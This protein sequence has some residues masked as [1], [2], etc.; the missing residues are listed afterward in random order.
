MLQN[1]NDMQIISNMPIAKDTIELVLKHEHVSKHAV[2]GQFLYIRTENHTLGRPISIADVDRKNGTVTI[3]F[4]IIGS[5]T[6]KLSAISPGDTVQALGPSG[7]GFPLNARGDEKLLI[8]GGGIGV[9]PLYFL[10]KEL[11]KQ[12]VHIT[13]V[14][15]F[16]SKNHVFYEGKFEG[17]AKTFIVTN[18][19]SYGYKG[20]VT[21]V[22]K[23]I[24]EVD[25]YYACGPLPMLQAI[26]EECKEI[27]GY[28]SLEERMGCGVGACLACVVPT[29]DG[30]YRKICKDGPVFPAKEVH[31]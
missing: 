24:N 6:R 30:G 17:F 10:A 9:P 15:G 13:C 4:K 31:L 2:P 22:M 11:S 18:D 26:K 3:L 7:N 29:N 25:S 19:G 16:Q 12:G 1:M 23:K 20:F 14:L 27:T 21:D 8:V 5:G 28:L